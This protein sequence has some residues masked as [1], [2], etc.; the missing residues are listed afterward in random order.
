M[1][2]IFYVFTWLENLI[3]LEFQQRES[4]AEIDWLKLYETVRLEIQCDVHNW[5][6]QL[7]RTLEIHA[8]NQA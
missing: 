3:S 8:A 2:R 7:S 6:P 5:K 1:G 4:I